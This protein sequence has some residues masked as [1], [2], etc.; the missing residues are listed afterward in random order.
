VSRPRRPSIDER[1]SSATRRLAAERPVE[2]IRLSDVA[3]EAGVSWP[4]VKRHV[5]ER[6]RLKDLVAGADAD[7]PSSTPDTRARLL[8]AAERVFAARGYE[9]ATLDDIAAEAGLT[10]GAVYWHF[11]SKT[12]LFVTLLREG[13]ASLMQPLPGAGGDARQVLYQ[14]L[15]LAVGRAQLSQ[16]WAKLTLEFAAQSRLPEVGNEVHSQ[17]R[18]RASATSAIIAALQAQDLVDPELETEHVATLLNALAAGLVLLSA[19]D[20]DLELSTFLPRAS[21]VLERGLRR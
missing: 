15:A 16:N 5:G 3:R 10:K 11:E 4:T 21:R 2:K 13:A 1:I 6:S 12:D 14:L 9:A 20:A 8:D 19:V 18:E 17:V 7:Q